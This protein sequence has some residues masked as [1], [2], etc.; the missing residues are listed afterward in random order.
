[1]IDWALRAARLLQYAAVLGFV[2][3]AAF[4]AGRNADPALSC[5]G[6][7]RRRLRGLLL[8]AAG[9]GFFGTA[10]WLALESMA[11]TGQWSAW[12]QLILSTHFGRTAAVR[13]ALLAG[14]A[15]SLLPANNRIA[16][17]AAV[18]L[19]VAAAVSF[20]WSGHGVMGQGVI[21]WLHAGCDVLHLLAAGLWIGALVA[22][23]AQA[24]RCLPD[25][26]RGTRNLAWQL[27]RFSRLGPAI[28][29]VLAATGVVNSALLLGR[30]PW[31]ALT[32]IPYGKVLLAKLTLFAL[33]LALAAINRVRLTPALQFG[34]TGPRATSGHRDTLRQLRVALLAESS[35]GLLVLA[36]V[37]VL[38]TLAP[39]ASG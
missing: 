29:G 1:L 22:L 28:V 39:P 14:A 20:A 23:S 31:H 30:D 3:V 12:P 18:G 24:L 16:A 38:G 37:A 10:A 8:C 25:D 13:A 6:A 26:L 5:D 11:L 19:G 27:A 4:H 2:G 9:A 15:A 32:G 21:R 33:M 7:S 34:A 17:T 36:A 35:L